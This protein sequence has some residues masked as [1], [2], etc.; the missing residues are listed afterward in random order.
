[1][2]TRR[3]G[4]RPEPV[5]PSACARDNSEAESEFMLAMQAYKGSSGRMFPTWS[6]VLEVLRDLGYRK[7]LV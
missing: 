1:M 4:V 7:S 2:V 3:E 6:E 5:A